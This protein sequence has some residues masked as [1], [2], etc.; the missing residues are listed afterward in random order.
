MKVLSVLKKKKIIFVLIGI[1]YALLR[2]YGYMLLKYWIFVDMYK[3]TDII[4]TILI[5]IC[6]VIN[7]IIPLGTDNFYKKIITFILG[8]IIVA[9]SSFICAVIIIFLTPMS[10]GD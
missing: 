3:W 5:F 7:T 6:I 10:F 8:C 4:S 2:M 1:L 9:I